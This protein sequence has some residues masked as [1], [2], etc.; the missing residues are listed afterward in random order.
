MDNN[1]VVIK[2]SNRKTLSIQITNQGKVMIRAPRYVS[3]RDI[4]KFLKKHDSWIQKGLKQYRVKS[5]Q[6][7][8]HNYSKQEINDFKKEARDKLEQK[9]KYFSQLMNVPYEKF[10]LSGAKKRWGSC[11]GKKTISISWRLIFAPEN[12]MN[13]VIIHELSHIK[14]MNHSK[15]FW[16]FVEKY[17]PMYKNHRKWLNENDYLLNVG[18]DLQI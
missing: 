8:K 11:S 3:G 16:E 6:L 5:T 14:Y 4:E 15:N 17:D 12:I 9:L 13:Y 18:V 1:Q 10:R 2:K 7:Q